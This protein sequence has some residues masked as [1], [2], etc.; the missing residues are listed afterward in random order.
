M[1]RHARMTAADHSLEPHNHEERIVKN[2]K[3]GS[4]VLGAAVLGSLMAT[5][6]AVADETAVEPAFQMTELSQGYL[7]ADGDDAA[8]A[9]GKCGEGKCG[10]GKC[11]EGKCGEGKCG[12]GKCGSA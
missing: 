9:E 6:V 12:E 5:Q 3:A 10:E 1:V 4:L 2:F 8:P 7:L 11:G